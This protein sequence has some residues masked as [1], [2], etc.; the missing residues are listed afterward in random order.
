MRPSI[1][2][3]GPGGG[4]QKF[5]ILLSKKTTKRG[6]GVKNRQFSD[7]IVYECPFVRKDFRGLGLRIVQ[8]YE[9]QVTLKI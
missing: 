4:G 7:D 8:K 5:Q 3:V 9:N 2:Y 6:E 1:N